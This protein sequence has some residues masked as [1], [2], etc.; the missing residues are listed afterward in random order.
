VTIILRNQHNLQISI[1]DYDSGNLR[2]VAKAIER[3]GVSPITTSDPDT[4][5]NSDAVIL[6]GVGSA[7]SAMHALSK[8]NLIEPIKKYVASGKPFFGICLGLQLLFDRTEEGDSDCL[9]I[10]SG[11]VRH[12][13]PTMKVPHMGWNT[14][15]IKKNHPFLTNIPS[16]EYFYFVHS[17]V[18]VPQESND[19][20]ATTHYGE[21]FCSIYANN[22]LIATQFHPEKSGD[23]GLKLYENFI[24]L[25]VAEKQ[26]L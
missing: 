7:P 9:G 26:K 3:Y 8:R 11:N 13:Q 23:M 4:I 24:A 6:P 25:C 17:Y 18:V 19:I 21:S 10:I 1:I 20:A 22:N 5:L 16:G 12:L 14:I 2:S 15:D